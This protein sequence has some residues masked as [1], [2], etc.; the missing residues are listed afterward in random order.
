MTK[1]KPTVSLFQRKR[2]P[3]PR[4][5]LKEYCL[6]TLIITGINI[7]CYLAKELAHYI[8]NLFKH[9]PKEKKEE[10]SDSSTTKEEGKKEA[11]VSNKVIDEICEIFPYFTRE[12][13]EK[14]IRVVNSF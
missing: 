8:C 2:A 6:Y 11:K 13:A 7:I 5:N 9:K 1:R 4:S 3:S 12:H 10:K 14:Y